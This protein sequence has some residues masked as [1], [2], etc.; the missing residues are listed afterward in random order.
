MK[1]ILGF[2]LLIICN[3]ASSQFMQYANGEPFLTKTYEEYKGSPFLFDNFVRARVTTANG[4]VYDSVL[5]NLDL[6]GGNLIFLR[7]DK[8]Y[9]F[10]DPVAE[11]SVKKGSETQTF[12]KGKSFSNGLPDVFVTPISAEPLL[13]T[14]GTINLVEGASYGS[15]SKQYRFVQGKTIYTVKDGLVSKMNLTKSD[16]EK[17]FEK[18][19]S[20]VNE[21]ASKNK[22][23]FKSEEGWSA[24]ANYY[25][26]LKQ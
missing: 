3:S 11:F 24:L 12:K 13:L 18:H 2:L 16:A 21:F 26:T 8:T 5:V 19:W 22:I 4:K 14:A 15:A 10:A 23:S 25:K 9:T 17:V 6:F 7:D 20:A 1:W